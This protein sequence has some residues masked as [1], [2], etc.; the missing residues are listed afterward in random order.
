LR[1]NWTDCTPTS[2]AEK[3]EGER[4]DEHYSFRDAG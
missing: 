2:L 1:I 3:K 4:V